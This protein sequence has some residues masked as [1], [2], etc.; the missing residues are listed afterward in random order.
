MI[1]PLKLAQLSRAKP[2]VAQVV[3]WYRFDPELKTFRRGCEG[4]T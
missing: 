1:D 2:L 3:C 4:D